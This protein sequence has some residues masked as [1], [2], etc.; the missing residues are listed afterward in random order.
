MKTEAI[1]H[2]VKILNEGG[3]VAYPTEA[4]FGLGC[5][6]QN[7]QSVIRL[8]KLKQRKKDKGLILIASS[9]DQLEPYIEELDDQ[10]KQRILPTWPG[11]VTWTLPAKQHTSKLLTG[12]HNTIAVRVTNH[13]IARQLCEKWGGALISTSANISTN[14]PTRNLHEVSRIFG[15]KINY[16]LDGKVGNLTQATQ[17]KDGQTGK[18]IRN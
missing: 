4:V 1:Q 15:D 13:P 11:S 7:E 10:T 16:I 6:P 5:D 2:A 12:R 8:L 17:I 18:I 3:I 14:P 9:F